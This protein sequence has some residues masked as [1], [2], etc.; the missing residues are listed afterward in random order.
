METSQGSRL[1]CFKEGDFREICTTDELARILGITPRRVRQ[2]ASDHGLPRLAEGEYPLAECAR[3]YIGFL[4]EQLDKFE[5]PT[6][7]AGR[8]RL[9]LAQAAREELALARDRGELIPISMY[10]NELEKI[11]LEFRSVALQVR[12]ALEAGTAKPEDVDKL[13]AKLARGAFHD[14]E[15]TDSAGTTAEPE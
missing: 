8:E 1:S 6:L 9:V 2:L 15:R 4:Q 14:A 10:G 13:L 11:C 3:W 7:R 5:N 12:R